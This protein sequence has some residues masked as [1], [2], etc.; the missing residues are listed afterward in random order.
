MWLFFYVYLLY[1]IV[2]AQQRKRRNRKKNKDIKEENNWGGFISSLLLL[3]VL[4]ILTAYVTIN[5]FVNT[6]QFP[7]T[8][9]SY[10]FDKRAKLMPS[11]DP[12]KSLMELVAIISKMI[13]DVVSGKM[14]TMPSK[15][16]IGEPDKI[17]PKPFQLSTKSPEEYGYGDHIKDYAALVIN[18]ST[19]NKNKIQNEINTTFKDIVPDINNNPLGTG[20]L[21][22][23]AAIPLG[24][25][26][27]FQTILSVGNTSIVST[28]K[29]FQGLT[30]GYFILDWLFGFLYFAI[31]MIYLIPY[32]FIRNMYELF[33]KPLNRSLLKNKTFITMS[34][35]AFCLSTAVASGSNLVGTAKT[36][37]MIVS[38]IMFPIFYF[39]VDFTPV[40]K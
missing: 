10:P 34:I 2:M 4:I 31:A 15:P 6:Q 20:V 24:L 25:S 5:S 28:M 21:F 11:F 39:I 17:T 29:Y 38:F 36:I 26:I 18:Q 23:F 7:T 37:G 13:N 40:K 33:Y 8:F 3:P 35:L 16:S 12:M 30:K 22:L 9:T 14:P 32:T 1:Q 19:M 27:A